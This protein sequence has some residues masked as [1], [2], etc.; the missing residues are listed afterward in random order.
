MISKEKPPRHSW[1][2]LSDLSGL[3]IASVAPLF[4]LAAAG[5]VLLRLAGA[6]VMWAVMAIATP[7]ILSSW[8]F[9]MLN[10]HYP[11]TGASYHWSR[12]ILGFGISRYQSWILMMAYFWSIP[13][14]I[15]PAAEE[16]LSL[17]GIPQPP[18]W[19]VIVV[20]GLW[21]SL[22]AWL[23]LRGSKTVARLTKVFM[24]MELIAVAAFSVFGLTHWHTLAGNQ[25][26]PSWHNFIIA[27][28]IGATIVDGWEIDSYAAEEADYPRKTPGMGG[29]V[30][31]LMVLV[32]YLAMFPLMLHATSLANLV[33]HP[34]VL[35]TW[36]QAL[37]PHHYWVAIIPIIASTAGSLWL[38]TF[39]L[40]KALF[41]MARD[42]MLPRFLASRNH[43]QTETW[44]VL[45]PL[46]LGWAVIAMQLLFSSLSAVFNL[47]LSTAGF[48]LILEFLFDSISAAVFLTRIHR[49]GVHGLD[50]KH[51][52]LQAVSYLTTAWFTMTVVVFLIYGPKAIGHSIDTMVAIML[53]AGLAFTLW[54]FEG[55][56]RGYH[57][58]NP[59]TRE[60]TVEQG[61]E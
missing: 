19:L 57:V 10:Q 18:S 46:G 51:S 12:R 30:G 55:R 58:F 39:I 38:T 20:S 1:L 54:R 31:A 41:A 4:S 34:D 6:D 47:V 56:W 26:T 17:A 9:R 23:L 13:P 15:I 24:A 48:F 3:S 29:I 44:S 27:M 33:S 21:I 37:S 36:A 11:N 25:T 49:G 60:L 8:L 61:E 52:G 7:F 35:T 22:S 50:H 14:I 2:S 59:D 42:R 16:S 32:F 53:A 40:S 28:V 5:S 45:L 43:F